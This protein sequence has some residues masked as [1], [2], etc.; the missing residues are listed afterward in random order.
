MLGDVLRMSIC[1][2]VWTSGVTQS[3]PP[4]LGGSVVCSGWEGFVE[5]VESGAA[6]RR[7]F[8]TAFS[9]NFRS[10]VKTCSV[11]G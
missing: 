11:L 1:F 8:L 10:E 9:I 3:R 7:A 4:D 2:D 5:T 6:T